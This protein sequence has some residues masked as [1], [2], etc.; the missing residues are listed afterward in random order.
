MEVVLPELAASFGPSSADQVFAAFIIAHIEIPRC[1]LKGA[2]VCAKPHGARSAALL[3][4]DNHE[5]NLPM[6]SRW[7]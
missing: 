6:R 2:F 4:G 1:G 5:N 7:W 3:Y